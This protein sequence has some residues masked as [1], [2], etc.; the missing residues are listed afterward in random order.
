MKHNNA[1]GY[2]ELNKMLKM[3]PCRKQNVQK[4]QMKLHQ[5]DWPTMHH[6]IAPNHRQARDTNVYISAYIAQH[7]AVMLGIEYWKTPA[8][9]PRGL[10]G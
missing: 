3:Y 6:T 7:S 4:R 9:L 10:V 1:H 2:G 5:L 8:Y